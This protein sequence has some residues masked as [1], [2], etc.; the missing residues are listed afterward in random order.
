MATKTR[1]A[2]VAVPLTQESSRHLTVRARLCGRTVRFI[3]DTGAG[4]TLIDSAAAAR[5]GL[6]MRAHRQKG[7]GVG[8]ASMAVNS[9]GRHDLHLAGVDLSRTKLRT[10]DLSHVNAGLKK[11][12]VRAIVGVIG[13]DVLQRYK[14]VIDYGTSRLMLHV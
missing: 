4:A 2:V 14:A 11:A 6:K 10:I 3:L 12:E 9:V 5:F 13:A 7:A 1:G 8:S